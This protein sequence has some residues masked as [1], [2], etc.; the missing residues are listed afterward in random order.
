MFLAIGNTVVYSQVVTPKTSTATVQDT[1]ASDTTNNYL[2]STTG[3][4]TVM[5][6]NDSGLATQVLIV[7]NDSAW[8]E[9]KRNVI[10]LYKGAK[11]KYEGFELA[12]DYIRLDRN[13]NVLFASGVKDDNGKYIG[14]PVVLFP[15]D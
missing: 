3:K 10:H 8:N 5:M 9:V 13:N 1:V 4:D 12:A 2:K 15:N 11:V 6:K 14:R 7:A